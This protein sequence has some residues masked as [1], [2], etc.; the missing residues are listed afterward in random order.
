MTYNSAQGNPSGTFYLDDLRVARL[1]ADGTAPE[2]VDDLAAS[3]AGDDLYLSWSEPYDGEGVVRYIVYRDTTAD[4]AGDSIAGTTQPEYTD[5]DAVGDLNTHY[6]Y[7]VKAA[8]GAGNKSSP[9][10]GAGEFD[11]QVVET[12]K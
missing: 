4:A 6:Y 10:S 11:R 5:P 3:K 8:D 7:T 12:N 1:N 2:A 9:S